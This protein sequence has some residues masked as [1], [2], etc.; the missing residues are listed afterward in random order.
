MKDLCLATPGMW[1]MICHEN[2]HQLEKW[3][4]Q[5]HSPFEWL[6]FAT[7]ELGETAKA[8]SEWHFRQGASEVVVNEAIQTATLMLKIAE[9]FLVIRK[10]GP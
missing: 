7:E 5:E 1:A 2:V 9:M 6:N 10:K 3:G 8:I 4:I